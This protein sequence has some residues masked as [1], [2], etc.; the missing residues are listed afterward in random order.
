[1]SMDN[2]QH[3]NKLLDEFKQIN[4]EKKLNLKTFM[5]ISGYPHFENVASNILA[6]F[7]TTDEE[8]GFNE[9]L[10]QSL[11][12]AANINEDFEMTGISVEREYTTPNNKRLDLVLRNSSVIIGIENKM[13]SDV[14]NDLIDYSNAL[15]KEALESERDVQYSSFIKR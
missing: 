8:H 13:F 14:K 15:E 10:F 2:M 11:I 1:M 7:F 5:Q 12:E 4:F 3:Y 6:F 9:L